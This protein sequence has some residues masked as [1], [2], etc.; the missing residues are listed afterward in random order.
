MNTVLVLGAGASMAFKYPL[1]AQLRDLI[2]ALGSSERQSFSIQAGLYQNQN[3]LGTFVHAFRRSQMYSIDAF[4]ARQP[5]FTQI[6]KKA[7]AALML[8]VEDFGVLSSAENDSNWYRLFFNVHSKDRLAEFSFA[9]TSIVTFNYD[10]SLEAFLHMAISNSYGVAH[11]VAVKKSEELSIVHVYGCIGSPYK[12]NQQYLEYGGGVNQ[13][14]VSA[15][16]ARL[17]VIPEG[18]DDDETL[19][20]ARA[21]LI[22]ADRIAFLGFGFDSM[23][24]ER[25][26]STTTCA[27]VIAGS[28]ESRSR[29]IYA[30]CMGLTVAEAIKA[31]I[32]L[33]AKSYP[34]ERFPNGF[35]P[36]NCLSMLR[37]TLALEVLPFTFG[38]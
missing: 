20:R 26:Q 13:D 37:E 21:M 6:G 2:F 17:R 23:N 15:A 11:S 9:G 5:D 31:Y 16:S 19:Q 18:R 3:E 36:L 35:Y 10:R 24:L 4:L 32:A 30:T 12:G 1:G 7:I 22:Q 29:S 38:F 8:E 27:C 28:S 14:R 33:G 25:L 34:Q